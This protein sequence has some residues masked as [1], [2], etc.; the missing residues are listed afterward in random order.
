MAFELS[1]Y[2]DRVGRRGEPTSLA[3]VHRAHATTIVFE[4]Y[5]AGLSMPAS[6]RG[7]TN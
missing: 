2:L 4:N 6:M 3:A 1:S 7:V 5:R